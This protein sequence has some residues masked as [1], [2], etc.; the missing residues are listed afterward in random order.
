VYSEPFII[1]PDK[2]QIPSALIRDAKNLAL[3]YV[4]NSSITTPVTDETLRTIGEALWQAVGDEAA[5][6][7][8]K[9]QAGMAIVPI[10]IC[11]D[12]AALQALPWECL[13]H[14][15]FKF[16]ARHSHFTFS[17][18]LTTDSPEIAPPPKGALQVLLFSSMPD[19]LHPEK[20]RLQVEEE[21]EQIVEALSP[22][23]QAGLV[24]LTAPSDGQ[25]SVLADHLKQKRYHLSV[26]TL[27]FYQ[28]MG[29][30]IRRVLIMK[31][32]MVN[33]YLKVR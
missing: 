14:P 15:E 24:E 22:L 12:D 10:I 6:S 19:D 17:R 4:Y 13:Y 8:H 31:R 25:K 3:Q 1:Y 33:F 26:I 23:M 2:H 18:Q 28:G 11:T 5:F 9:Q 21:Y 27:Y 16:L 29:I 30:F 20:G 7:A 32:I